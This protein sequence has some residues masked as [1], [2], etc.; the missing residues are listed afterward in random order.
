[1]TEKQ[2]LTPDQVE[3]IYN[4]PKQ[5]L[6]NWRRNEVDMLLIKTVRIY[7]LLGL[8]EYFTWPCPSPALLRLHNHIPKIKNPATSPHSTT[9]NESLRLRAGRSACSF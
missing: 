4:I 5:T 2:T 8:G 3:E 1:M 6:A 9:S 7:R